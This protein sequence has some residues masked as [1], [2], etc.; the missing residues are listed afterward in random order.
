MRDRAS[1]FID[2]FD[3]IFRTE[4]FKVLKTPVRTHVANAFAVRWIG[5]SEAS[6]S[7]VSIVWFSRQLGQVRSLTTSTHYDHACLNSGRQHRRGWLDYNMPRLV[8]VAS[9]VSA[10]LW[11]PETRTVVVAPAAMRADAESSRTESRT[12]T[13]SHDRAAKPPGQRLRPNHGAPTCVLK[14]SDDDV[15]DRR[16]YRCCASAGGKSCEQLPWG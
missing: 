11:V 7:T 15:E 12:A 1:Q 6:S 13:W 2:A 10:A 16:H 3:E 4:G 5:S 14:G 9:C 8:V